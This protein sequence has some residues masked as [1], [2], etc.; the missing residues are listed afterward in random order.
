MIFMYWI[1]VFKPKALINNIAVCMRQS[2]FSPIHDYSPVLSMAYCIPSVKH[3]LIKRILGI[4]KMWC[5]MYWQQGRQGFT[6]KISWFPL[7]SRL[8]AILNVYGTWISLQ[9][10]YGSP[11]VPKSYQAYVVSLNGWRLANDFNCIYKCNSS[12]RQQRALKWKAIKLSCLL[13][14]P[15][16]ILGLINSCY[17]VHLL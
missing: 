6:V 8:F 4:C 14:R 10:F 9:T 16:V 17:W 5:K 3:C 2:Q 11:K 1:N 13:V 15:L 12:R 7:L